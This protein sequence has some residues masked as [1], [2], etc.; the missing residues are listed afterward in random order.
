MKINIQKTSLRSDIQKLISMQGTSLRITP[1]PVTRDT[2]PSRSNIL[3]MF[4]AIIR[5]LM[6]E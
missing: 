2:G 3:D 1:K 5:K 6:M 4:A